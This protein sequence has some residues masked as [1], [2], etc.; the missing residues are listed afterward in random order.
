MPPPE[1]NPVHDQT[2]QRIPDTP[3]DMSLLL[4]A[5]R[6]IIVVWRERACAAPDREARIYEHA[7]A[8]LAA[9]IS[10]HAP[11]RTIWI[12]ARCDMVQAIMA[13]MDERDGGRP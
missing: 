11:M 13:A 5:L 8:D 6:R 10:G 1:T 2:T 9:V 7:E 12:A 4:T 3:L